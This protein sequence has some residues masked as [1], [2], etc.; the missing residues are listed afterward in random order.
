MAL[1]LIGPIPIQTSFM[2]VSDIGNDPYV[3]ILATGT[4]MRYNLVSLS[5]TVGMSGPIGIFSAS[6]TEDA[7]VVADSANGGWIGFGG[8]NYAINLSSQTT[9]SVIQTSS[10]QYQPWGPAGIFLADVDY[11]MLTPA[12]TSATGLTVIVDKNNDVTT[13]PFSFQALPVT[14]Y[15]ECVS[16]GKY[17]SV[18]VPQSSLELWACTIN[19]NISVCAD[20]QLLT[21][22]WTNL[23]DC[24]N[25]IKYPYCKEGTFCGNDS[26]NGPCQKIYDD[27]KNYLSNNYACIVNPGKFFSDTKWWESKIFIGIVSFI[28]IIIIILIVIIF[29]ISKRKIDAAGETDDNN[30]VQTK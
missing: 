4:S 24:V 25:G 19:P 13:G 3:L 2:I 21:D 20:I 11:A 29:V 16:G 12:P 9:F 30:T 14:W 10:P 26:C 6:G 22:G 18:N 5:N 17:I 23:P 15:T 1:Q 7:L 28:T 8:M 27:C